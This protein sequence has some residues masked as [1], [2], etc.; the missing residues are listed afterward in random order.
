MFISV[1]TLEHNWNSVV[2]KCNTNFVSNKIIVVLPV[3][4]WFFS[5]RLGVPLRELVL[6]Y[7]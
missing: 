6:E 1:H 2:R 7:V 5:I 4:L 3:K